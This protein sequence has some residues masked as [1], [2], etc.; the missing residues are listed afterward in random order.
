[1]FQHIMKESC[2]EITEHMSKSRLADNKRMSDLL[3]Y[4]FLGVYLLCQWS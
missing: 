3:L 2:E 1:M 4:D